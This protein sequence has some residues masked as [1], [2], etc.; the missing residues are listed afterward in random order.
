MPAKKPTG[1]KTTQTELYALIAK[2]SGQPDAVVSKVMGAFQ[3][4]VLDQS[5][6]GNDIALGIGTFKRADKPARTGTN[7]SNGQKIKIAASKGVK[8][9][10][11]AKFKKHLN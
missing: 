5:Y 10:V 8:F 3:S 7:P 2:S 11:G 1:S 6:K 4:T 9:Q